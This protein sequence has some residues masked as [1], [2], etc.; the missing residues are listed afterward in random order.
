V[1]AILILREGR[2]LFL[3][4]SDGAEVWVCGGVLP[5]IDAV[6][7]IP[8]GVDRAACVTDTYVAR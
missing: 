2:I 3:Q 8:G 6:M 7:R 1:V 4:A 5:D